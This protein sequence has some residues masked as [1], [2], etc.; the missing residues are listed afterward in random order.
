MHRDRAD[1]DRLFAASAFGRGATAAR[2]DAQGLA[3]VAEC[4]RAA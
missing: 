2:A 3:L 1:V 4:V